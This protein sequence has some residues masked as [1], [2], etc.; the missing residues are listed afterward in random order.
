MCISAPVPR[1]LDEAFCRTRPDLIPGHYVKITVTDTGPGIAEEIR[2]RI[3]DPF[4][5]AQQNGKGAGL[6]LAL[7][8]AVCQQHGGCVTAYN[9]L[10]GGACFTLYLPV[11]VVPPE[12]AVKDVCRI[13]PSVELGGGETVLLAEDD[14]MVR[15]ISVDIL[16][17]SGYRV[18][19]ASDGAE[20]L[21]SV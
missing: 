15:L 1:I 12:R 10:A 17:R 2:D 13:G 16:E 6:G 11:S 5:S 7:V 21:G 14:E 18:L 8:Y 4:F 9:S 3:F 19:A 20:A